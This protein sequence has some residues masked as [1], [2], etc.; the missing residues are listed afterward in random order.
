MTPKKI[1]ELHNNIVKGIELSF[2]RLVAQKQ[3]DDEE[4]IFSQN[5]KIVR[6]K[7]RDL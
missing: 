1:E 2:K 7:A 3:K 4:L 6:I 5:G